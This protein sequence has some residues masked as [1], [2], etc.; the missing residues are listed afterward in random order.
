MRNV[1]LAAD[2]FRGFPIGEFPYDPDHTAMGEYQYVTPEGNPG[3]WVDQVCN[4]TWNGTGPT[5]IITEQDGRHAMECTRVE[6][7]HPHRMFPTL[8]TGQTVWKDYDAEV[9]LRRLSLRGSAGLAFCM[10]HSMDTLVFSFEGKDRLCIAY[11]HKEEVRILCECP[12]ACD[13]DTDYHLRVSLQDGHADCFVTG[14]G[15]E[16]GRLSLDHELVA[17]GGK[18]G[19]TADCPTR[20]TDFSVC[21]SEETAE[22]E[23]IPTLLLRFYDRVRDSGGIF[24]RVEEIQ[25][26][27]VLSVAASGME[28]IPVWQ[29]LTDGGT[30]Y[31][32]YR[33]DRVLTISG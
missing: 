22:A 1:C 19:L 18:V 10:N 24:S 17:R 9:T 28:L 25:P 26:G 5:W 15:E 31:Y 4:Y 6:K 14:G 32:D 11:R 29:F 7:N 20:F 16:A 27:Y 2:D 12:I 8:Q 3:I 33:G 13:A 23:D 30:W 21:V